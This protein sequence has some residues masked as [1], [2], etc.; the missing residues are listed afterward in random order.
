MT[1]RAQPIIYKTTQ[2]KKEEVN[3]ILNKIKE[4]NICH[5]TPIKDLI[6]IC[7]DFIKNDNKSSI[8]GKIPF[9][10][11]NRTILYTLNPVYNQESVIKMKYNK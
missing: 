11:G 8:S 2:Q 1:K 5:F 7:L 10:E 4:L 9:D 3:K 6:N